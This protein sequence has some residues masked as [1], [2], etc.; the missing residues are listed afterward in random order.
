MTKQEGKALEILVKENFCGKQSV[1][2]CPYHTKTWCE[3]TCG[4]YQKAEIKA[5]YWNRGATY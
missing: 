4:I 3:K 5:K 2:A 1:V